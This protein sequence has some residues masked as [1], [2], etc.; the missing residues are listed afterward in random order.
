MSLGGFAS[1]TMDEC[2]V[3]PVSYGTH[4]VVVVGKSKRDTCGISTARA[5]YAFIVGASNILMN[6]GKRMSIFSIFS[7]CEDIFASDL[8]I[9]SSMIDKDG[10]YHSLSGASM[11]VPHVTGVVAMYLSSLGNT[12]KSPDE[13][14]DL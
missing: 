12:Q 11:V 9:D 10:S 8:S 5:E 6:F 1:T 7:P 14:M 2:V 3:G 4:V 13:V